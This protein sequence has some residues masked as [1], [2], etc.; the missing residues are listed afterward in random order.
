MELQIRT[1]LMDSIAEFG[2]AAHWRYHLEQTGS[3]YVLADHL[4]WYRDLL[5]ATA[6]GTGGAD[7]LG[8][9]R[10]DVLSA[11]VMVLTPKNELIPMPAGSTALDFAFALHTDIG[12]HCAGVRVNGKAVPMDFVLRS[13]DQV[14]ILTSPSAHPTPDWLSRV[15]GPSARAKIRR[16]LRKAE[17]ERLVGV[18]KANLLREL[19][20]LGLPLPRTTGQW[21]ALAR[22][23]AY[24]T[25]TELLLGA[26]SGA[27]G[28][29][30]LLSLLP[31]ETPQHERSSP[32]PPSRGVRLGDLR[33]L[34]VRFAACCRP[35]PGDRIAAFITRGRG[36]SI[37]R[38]ECPNAFR[39]DE[40]RWI[41]LDWDV[42]P[43][44]SFTAYLSVLAGPRRTVLAT[45]EAAI[46][47]AH[48]RLA[49][50]EILTEEQGWGRWLQVV[51]IV[52]DTHHLDEV[53]GA[54]RRIPGV[55][56]AMRGR[57]GLPPK[58]PCAH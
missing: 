2:V 56:E 23:L 51:V 3:R 20:R 45:L 22:S 47:G 50:L 43:G 14:E 32:L 19:R 15:A 57:P 8:A 27:V 18:G 39:G 4:Q 40:A 33:S 55:V 34:A 10:R 17:R 52:R 26:A 53:L 46:E 54:V 58:P 38:W 5:E 24:P 11:E 31:H 12:L 48:A 35:I 28:R 30:Q 44:E 41:A 6:Q 36:A 29:A 13:G 37:H 42:A 16:Y 49:G 25:V 7:L 21:E 9:L 1:S